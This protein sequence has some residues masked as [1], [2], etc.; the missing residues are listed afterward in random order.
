MGSNVATALPV[1]THGTLDGASGVDMAL[2]S[3]R[4]VLVNGWLAVLSHV[5]KHVG[6]D[7][8]MAVSHT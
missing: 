5:G 4:G 8:N 2:P 3:A 1:P 7:P 6:G